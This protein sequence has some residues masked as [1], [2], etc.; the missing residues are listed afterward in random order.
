MDF[1][2]TIF[3]VSPDGGS[4]SFEALLFG[5]LI[6]GSCSF[7]TRRWRQRKGGVVVTRTLPG[8]KFLS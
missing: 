4:G 6:V 8:D 3:G 2:E 7:A 5:V 1:I